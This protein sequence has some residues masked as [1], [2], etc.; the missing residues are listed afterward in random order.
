ME[1]DLQSD[2]SKLKTV[3]EKSTDR[4]NSFYILTK[5]KK[6]T[7]SLQGTIREIVDD[8]TKHNTHEYENI[9]DIF[10]EKILI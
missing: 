1:K 2:F 4:Q 6:L 10:L 3:F 9:L 5:S 7:Q 8:L